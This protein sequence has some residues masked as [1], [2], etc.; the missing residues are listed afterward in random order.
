[1]TRFL[2]SALLTFSFSSI[3]ANDVSDDNPE[4]VAFS[5]HNSVHDISDYVIDIDHITTVHF[6]DISEEDFPNEI[7]V[8][9]TVYLESFEGEERS[10]TAELNLEEDSH[11]KKSRLLDLI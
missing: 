8:R 1:M 5:K 9:M 7:L 2:L 6:D 3:Q 10:I 11:S 4:R